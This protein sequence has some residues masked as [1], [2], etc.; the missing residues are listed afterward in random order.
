VRSKSLAQYSD[1]FH[2]EYAIRIST[3]N[4][5]FDTTIKSVPLYA[6]H[7]INERGGIPPAPR[8]LLRTFS[9]NG[10][11]TAAV[12]RE[13]RLSGPES[14]SPERLKGSKLC[15]THRCSSFLNSGCSDSLVSKECCIVFSR[16]YGERSGTRGRNTSD[17]GFD[18]PDRDPVDRLFLVIC[19]PHKKSR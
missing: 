13:W 2:P 12:H 6:V 14:G 10:P 15:A 1:Q 16:P 17:T 4:F 18:S 9:C 8:R 11:A 19:P 7:C 5:G 3:K